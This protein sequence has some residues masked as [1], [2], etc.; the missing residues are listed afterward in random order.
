M[1]LFQHGF[2]RVWASTSGEQPPS[3]VPPPSHIPTA[4][5]SGLGRAE[6]ESVIGS[7]LAELSD[8]SPAAKRRKERGKYTT[9]TAEDRAKIG[10]YALEHGNEK[11]R[12]RFLA[13]FPNLKESTVRNFKRAYKDQLNVQRK[14][15]HPQ[16]VTA[17]PSKPRGRPPVLLELDE[18]LIKFL[19]A[20]R[21]KG[22]VINIHVVRATATALI[23]SNPSTSLNL[24]NILMPRTW[25][26]SVY[27]RIGFTRRMGTTARP[28]VPKGLFDECRFSYLRDIEKKM[29]KY[30]IPPQLVL[31]ADQTPSSYVSVGRSTMA[32]HGAKS[33]A[34]KGLTDKR[35]IT[36][37]FVVTLAGD[38][39]PLQIIYG[40]KTQRS[41]PRGF[42][43]PSGFSISQNPQHWSNEEETMKLIDHVINPYIV[44]KR[45]EL[46]LPVMQK[47]LVIWDVFK[48]QMT[49][50]VLKKLELLNCEFVP[51]PPNMTHFFQ[52]LDLTVNQSAKH[53]MRN[54]FIAYYSDAVKQELDKGSQ[55]EDI[56]V[57]LRLTAIKPLHAQWLV[58]MYD[59]FTSEKGRQII[60]KGWKKA[61]I[62]GLLDGTT[63]IPSEDPFQD[64]YS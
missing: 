39:L 64:I 31:N 50:K 10:K 23:S 60:L 57:D 14:Q 58:K 11:A 62:I 9:Y 53:F 32:E 6:Y 3:A 36:L 16:P 45:A 49:D 15:L 21:S 59:F 41:H 37:T 35:N 29:T 47:A 13:Q 4:E 24:Q 43:F 1:S 18:K 52:P 5:E 19:R 42:E 33:V 25:V 55:I 28:P 61:G 8:P 48:G 27:Q 63:L 40:G 54:K 22:G 44:K 34:I 38:F 20:L 12:R 7:D 2:R 46:Q 17:L 56:E 51:V 26:Q 30:N